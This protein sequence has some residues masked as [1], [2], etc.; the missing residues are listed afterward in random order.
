[1]K[2]FVY[3]ACPLSPIEGETVEGNIKRA[4]SI[5]RQ[6]CLEFPDVVFLTQWIVNV[7]VFE[8]TPEFRH[9]G[10]ER[11][12][13]IIKLVAVIGGELWL[14]G[15][16]VSSGMKS[17]ALVAVDL[18]IKCCRVGGRRVEGTRVAEYELER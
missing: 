16:R 17:E 10:M 11:N 2:K 13:A 4:K 9:K 14:A 3:L 5:Y 1:V 12:F 18:G 8:D 6:L 7:E 15:P